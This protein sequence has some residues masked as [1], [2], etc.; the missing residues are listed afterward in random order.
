M[1]RILKVSHA[2]PRKKNASRGS[3]KPIS[4]ERLK[5]IDR[6]VSAHVARMDEEI[7]YAMPS[8]YGRRTGPTDW[9]AGKDFIAMNPP[10]W[11]GGPYFSVRDAERIYELGYRQIV[12]GGHDGFTVDLVMQ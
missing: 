9:E 3:P 5:A 1:S 11:H 4:G 12:I 2:K 8:M 10:V 7:L 6:D